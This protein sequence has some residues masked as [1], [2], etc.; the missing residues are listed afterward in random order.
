MESQ[1]QWRI[2]NADKT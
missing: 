2:R 1:N